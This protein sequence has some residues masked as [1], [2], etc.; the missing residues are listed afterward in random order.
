[1][2]RVPIVNS[3][4]VEEDEDDEG[5]DE[6]SAADTDA[7]DASETHSYGSLTSVD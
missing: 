1:M 3:S 7:T 2:S 5:D 4:V 6:A